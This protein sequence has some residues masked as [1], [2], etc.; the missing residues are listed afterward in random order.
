MV[1]YNRMTEVLDGL[2][3][4]KVSEGAIANMLARA[5]KPFAANAADIAETV[6][7][8]PS[9]P[10]TRPRIGV[11]GR[12]SARVCGKTHWQWTFAAASAAYHTIA[13]TMRSM[14]PP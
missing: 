6:R 4:L 2:L 12:L 10:A 13:P 11:R 9:S 8:S 14:A 1:S 3:G 5:A 7:T